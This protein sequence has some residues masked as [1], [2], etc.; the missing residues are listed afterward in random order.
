MKKL[1]AAWGF[2]II[3]IFSFQCLSS[4]GKKKKRKLAL[5]KKKKGF[6]LFFELLFIYKLCLIIQNLESEN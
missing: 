4:I 5:E 1:Q 6:F 2:I 3:T